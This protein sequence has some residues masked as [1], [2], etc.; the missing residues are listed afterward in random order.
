M[1]P[2]VNVDA[3]RVAVA[4][5]R[6]ELDAAHSL[7]Y[8]RY[9]SRGYEVGADPHARSQPDT[10]GVAH[11]EVTIVAAAASGMIGTCTLGFD[12]PKGLRAEATYGDIIGSARAAGC[13]VGEIT[14]LAVDSA[15][16][17]AV[18]ASLF[19][20]AYVA[21]KGIDEVTDVFVEVNPRHVL[22]YTRVLGFD[23]AGD[24]RICERAA[25]P[26]VLLRAEMNALAERLAELA[27]R[28][29]PQASFER[30]A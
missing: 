2:A 10:D 1:V 7:V 25:A 15:D 12:G 19:N 24:E 26:A 18:L 17:M 3:L 27:R 29:I 20:L 4:D 14:R 5:S 21:G 9:R 23:V 11:R 8:R 22:F 30:A 16:S 6:A 28:A 13:R